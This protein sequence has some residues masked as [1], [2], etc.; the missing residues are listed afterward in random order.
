MVLER[1]G[2][3]GKGNYVSVAFV[4]RCVTSTAR[5]KL[6]DNVKVVVPPTFE[7]LTKSELKQKKKTAKNAA[8]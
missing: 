3:K 7:G 6:V 8:E 4:F 2:K 5:V 1:L